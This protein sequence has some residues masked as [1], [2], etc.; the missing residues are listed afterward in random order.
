LTTN[1]NFCASCGAP[2][3]VP[4][5]SERR[6]VTVVFADLAGSTELASILDP[7]RFREV[8]ASF[9]GMVSEEIAW[10]GGVAEGFIGDAVLGVFGTPVAHDDDAVRAVRAALSIRD[11]AERLGRQLGLPSPMGVRIGVNTG[12]VAVGTPHDRNLVFGSEVNIGA[13]L[14]QAAAPGEILAGQTSVD[15]AGDRIWFGEP[16]LV[17]AK[18]VL[19]QLTAWPVLGLGPLAKRDR[20]RVPM[21]NRRRELALLEDTFDR[22]VVRGR[23]HLATL[24]G[25]PGIGKSRVADEFVARLPDGVTVLAGRSSPFE[26]E[27]TFA[28]LAEMVVRHVGEVGHEEAAAMAR[29]AEVTAGWPH[30]RSARTARRLALVLGF[31]ADG[32]EEHRYHAAEIRRGFASMIEAIAVAGPVVLVFE[33][34]HQADPALLDLIEQL[35]REV[36]RLPVLVVCVARWELLD[37]RPNW[38]GGLADAVTLWVEPLAPEH[39]VRLAAEAGDLD[40]ASAE[41]VATHAGGNPFFIVEIA[42]ML[43][44]ED[45]DVP[46]EGPAPSGTLLPATV[47]AV[48]A[49]RIDQLSPPARELVRRASV[50]PR[51]RFDEGELALLVEPRSELLDEAEDEELLARDEHGPG[52]WRFRSDAIRDVAYGALAKRQRQRLHLRVANQLAQPETEHRYPR[53]IAFHLEQAARAALDLNPGDRQLAE[54]AVEALAAAGDLARRR[55]ESRAAIDLY[56]RALALAGPDDGWGRREAWIVSMLGEARYWLGEFDEAEDLFRRALTLA[57][58]DDVVTAHATRFLADI[59]MTIRGDDHLASALFERSLEAARRLGEPRVLARTLLMAGRV[60]LGRGRLEEANAM[61][62][63]ALDAARGG[64]TIDAWGESRA[65]AG[66]AAV[67]GERGSEDR[68]LALGNEAL[69]VAEQADQPFTAAAA[70]QGVAASLRRLW[71][72]DEAAMHA[73]LAVR[74]LRELGARW[75]LAGALGERGAVARLAGRLED[76]ETDLREAWVLCRD[77]RERA[78]VSWVSAELAR[79]LGVRGDVVAGRAVLDEPASRAGEGEFSSSSSLLLAEAVLAWLWHDPQ[80]ALAR[81]L[82]ALAV[83]RSLG[84]PNETDAVTWWIASL[85][86]SDP[87]GGHQIASAAR[88]RLEANGWHQAVREPE[89]I[90]ARDGAVGDG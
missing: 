88:E 66:L 83:V 13:R 7:E 67:E 4:E 9:H 79:T 45:R 37:D 58:G 86:G 39:A 59:T 23:A 53:T 77:L 18:G 3:A 17:A 75:E 60:P 54:R 48:V 1:A 85:F 22:V 81:S 61:F 46:P 89:L 40:D 5:A 50:F 33:D 51:G 27:A 10:L 26:E 72:L 82:D 65:L 6:V 20:D 69:G 84:L 47:Q 2:V 29:L 36:R 12:S 42:G 80:A 74:T 56:E 63:E 31:G 76:A 68:A 25:E 71:R 57:G 49:A 8:L 52:V 11:Q 24:L 28:P 19:E 87:A 78:L 35:V 16:R 21:V 14:Q 41:R 15:L 62:A 34:L 38:A 73:D 44:R 32:T 64:E 70:H 90:V 30:T 55:I 43:A